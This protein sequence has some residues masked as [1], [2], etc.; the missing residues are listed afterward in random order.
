M[1]K[2]R[3]QKSGRTDNVF[4]VADSR[5]QLSSTY[6]RPIPRYFFIDTEV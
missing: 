2:T 3:L 6:R 5:R 1:I 4:I